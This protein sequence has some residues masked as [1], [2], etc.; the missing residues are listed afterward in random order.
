MT[1]HH[2]MDIS[3]SD[4]YSFFSGKMVI[5]ANNRNSV[6]NFSKARLVLVNKTS[7]YVELNVPDVNHKKCVLCSKTTTHDHDIIY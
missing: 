7:S 2:S 3:N 6:I 1:S 4:T 5:D